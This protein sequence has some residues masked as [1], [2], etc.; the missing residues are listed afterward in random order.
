M[1]D[2]IKPALIMRGGFACECG[3]G[4][5]LHADGFTCDDIDECADDSLNECSDEEPCANT[6]GSYVCGCVPPVCQPEGCTNPDAPNYQPDALLDDGSCFVCDEGSGLSYRDTL[7]DWDCEQMWGECWSRPREDR[8]EFYFCETV[9]ACELEGEV[10]VDVFEAERLL[11]QALS[12]LTEPPLMRVDDHSETI[13]DVAPGETKQVYFEALDYQGAPTRVFAYIGLPATASPETPVPGIVLVHGGGGTAFRSWVDRWTERG[14]AAI[15][16]AVEGQTDQ[17]ASQEEIDSGLAVGNRRKHQASGPARVGAYGDAHLPLDEQWM[18]HAAADTILAHSLLKSLPQVSDEQ[19]GLMGISWGGVI[20]ATVMGI[21]QRWAF[22]IPTYGNGH[23]FDIPN[24]FGS[25]LENNDAYRQLWDPILWVEG[26]EMPSLWLTWLE[27]NNFSHDSQAETYHRAPGERMVSIV[28]E[29]GHGHAAAWNRP[30]SYDFADSVISDQSPW[31]QQQELSEIEGLVEVTFASEKPLI[32][33]RLVY[34]LE[35]GWTGE[36]VWSEAAV[37]SLTEESIGIW[38]VTATLPEGVTAW[39]VNVYAE[40]SDT[41][42]QYQYADS[43]LVVSS[44]YQEVIGVNLSP[45][46]GLMMGHPLAAERSSAQATLSFSAPSAIE[47]IEIAVHSESHPGAFCSPR[48]LPWSLKSPAP[49]THAI[50]VLFDNQVAGLLEGERATATLNVVWR[51]LDGLMRHADLP[52]EVVVRSS[53]DIVYRENALWSSQTVYAA[54]RVTI[55]E[56]AEV[57]L[58]V[59]QAVS[60]L[61][62]VDGTLAMSQTQT[63]TVNDDFAISGSG[64]LQ[65]TDGVLST[66]DNSLTVD[67]LIHINGGSLTAEMEGRSRNIAGNGLVEISAGDMSFV[68]GVPSNVLQLNTNMRI[69]GGTVSLSGQIYIGFTRHTLFEVI[70]DESTI[71]MVRLNMSGQINK[72][73]IVFRLD[74]SGVSKINVPGWMN[75]GSAQIIVDGSNY[76]GGSASIVLIDSNN[77]VSPIPEANISLIGFAQGLNASIEQDSTNGK[78]W[79]RL[80]IE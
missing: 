10:P 55:A 70:G 47:I 59:D 39:F 9:N 77:L 6:E 34:S 75:L 65:L 13:A 3:D 2:V 72:G 25:A 64:V 68:N 38:K 41:T 20:A 30:E 29:M 80:I 4:Y 19:V 52:I 31:C 33:A 46:D 26:A 43:E 71:S 11:V 56:G 79:V 32:D 73:T 69:S 36:M 61:S 18:Y 22:V 58:D 44:D 42:D 1:E 67:G 15:S 12:T 45:V 28:P 5:L 8:C 53:F 21:D 37:S 27:E 35:S 54:D 60:E 50:E 48:E 7:C 62:V 57:S 76:T 14:Y 51:E 40:G 49:S 66:D 16:I 17:S 63:L 24:Y 78:D 23:K 74:E